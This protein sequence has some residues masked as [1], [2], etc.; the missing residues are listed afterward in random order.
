MLYSVADRICSMPKHSARKFERSIAPEAISAST[1]AAIEC[2]NQNDPTS[3]LLF[4]MRALVS[5]AAL[6][7]RAPINTR[8]PKRLRRSA[9]D[10][11]TD[12]SPPPAQSRTKSS[13]VA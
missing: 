6:A 8:D 5:K 2:G 11:D 7:V 13:G 9:N 12:V 1:S 10:T 4:R 3:E